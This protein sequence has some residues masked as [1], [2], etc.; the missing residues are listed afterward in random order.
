[1]A[2]L[3]RKKIEKILSGIRYPG[4]TRDIVSFGVINNIEIDD[5][6]VDIVLKFTTKN[7]ET[8][9]Q[10]K[11]EIRNLLSERLENVNV[12][13][14]ETTAQTQTSAREKGTGDPWAGRAPIEGIKNIIAV[15]SGKGGV[16]KS[17]VSTN[18]AIALSR[19][20][21]KIGLMD[22]DIYG[23]SVH[24]MMGVEERPMVNESQKII[25]IEKFGIKMMSM[26][27]L[28]DSDAPLIWRGPLVMKAVEQFLRDVV[29][30]ELDALVIDLPPGTGDA[31]LTLVQKTPLSG[32]II[33]TTPQEVALVDA[34]RGLKMFQKVETRVLGLVENMSYFICPNCGA[35]TAIFG[36]EGG[37]R[38]AGELNIPLLGQI[39]IEP[40]VT[41]AG[42]SGVPVV[43]SH[44]DSES[45]RAFLEIAGKIADDSMF[46]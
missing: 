36:S 31:Q 39:P 42:D 24:I 5:R 11:S 3:D 6:N 30:G 14:K 13:I 18:L 10:I 44:P 46:Q 4:F 8:R 9:S 19:K 34:R 17:T 35:R 43:A 21:L 12:N 32:A 29:W 26:G 40:Q 33:V 41:E 20:G 28:I 1:M 16:G 27:F 22:S 38:A 23:P 37:N 25:P 45:A 7:E 2:Q 15:A